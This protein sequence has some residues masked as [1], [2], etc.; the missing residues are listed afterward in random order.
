MK[1]IL[2]ILTIIIF[3]AFAKA[4]QEVIKVE[5]PAIVFKAKYG[6]TITKDEVLI[7]LIDVLEDSRCPTG[8]DCF[9]EGQVRLTVQITKNSIISK[10]KILYKG[11]NKPIIYKDGE[12]TFYMN[13][14]Q[15]YPKDQVKIKKKDYVLLIQKSD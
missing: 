1:Y 9:W 5:V 8:V 15:P 14:L 10:K 13:G 12:T 7:K 4:Q 11:N 3:S 2:S 6:E